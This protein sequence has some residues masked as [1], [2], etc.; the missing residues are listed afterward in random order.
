[1]NLKN[2]EKPVSSA[3]SELSFSKAALDCQLEFFSYINDS[4]LSFYYQ[5]SS[6]RAF[7]DST[8]T[9]S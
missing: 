8:I 3:S 4:G 9:F 7:V 2:Y 1:M 5:I 6:Q